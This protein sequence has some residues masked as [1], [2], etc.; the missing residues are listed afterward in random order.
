MWTRDTAPQPSKWGNVKIDLLSITLPAKGRLHMS[1]SFPQRHL[2]GCYRL[3][4]ILNCKLILFGTDGMFFMLV[5]MVPYFLWRRF[6]LVP[7]LFCFSAW[8]VTREISSLKLNQASFMPAT[9]NWWNV[10]CFLIVLILHHRSLLF[11]SSVSDA[12]PLWL[13][14]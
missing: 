12:L 7:L 8:Q 1:D 3:C 2:R 9:H 13:A 11:I 4:S 10:T 5:V 6:L 14:F